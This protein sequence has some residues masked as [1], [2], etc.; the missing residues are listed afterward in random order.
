MDDRTGRG[1]RVREICLPRKEAADHKVFAHLHH[2]PPPL[3][4]KELER[5]RWRKQRQFLGERQEQCER[6]SEAVRHW[7][8]KG[9]T[10][11]VVRPSRSSARAIKMRRRHFLSASAR[12]TDIIFLLPQKNNIRIQRSQAT[13]VFRAAALKRFWVLL[14]GQKYHPA[15][16]RRYCVLIRI[17]PRR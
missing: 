8:D 2:S 6:A 4:G 13:R 10:G 11:V 9:K 14:A 15:G 16:R 3:R 12:R 1:E 5:R 17:S 7:S